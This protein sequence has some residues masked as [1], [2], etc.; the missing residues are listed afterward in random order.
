MKV[1]GYGE[2][3][4]FYDQISVFTM[5]TNFYLFIYLGS[6]AN[7]ASSLLNNVIFSA[8]FFCR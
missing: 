3:C 5:P 1:W 2:T 8:V 6:K 7:F 4:S